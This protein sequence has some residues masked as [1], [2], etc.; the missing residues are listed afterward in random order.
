MKNG[1][2]GGWKFL[3][4]A[5]QRLF[6]F[7]AHQHLYRPIRKK[8][9]NLQKKTT[10][11]KKSQPSWESHPARL[12]SDQGLSTVPDIAVFQDK[13]IHGPL[14]LWGSTPWQ[15]PELP[16]PAAGPMGGRETINAKTSGDKRCSSFG[17]NGKVNWAS[18]HSVT[19][20]TGTKGMAMPWVSGENRCGN[21]KTP[22]NRGRGRN[23]R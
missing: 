7:T 13:G 12:L 5:M 21:S 14:S 4:P 22:V 6:F 1:G 23:R 3:N 2:G 10:Q 18:I 17:I 19:D 11:K 8:S 20:V 16:A 9:L 15:T